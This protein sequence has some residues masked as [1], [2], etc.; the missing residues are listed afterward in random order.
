MPIFSDKSQKSKTT[1]QQVNK[2]TRPQVNEST[3]LYRH[4]P[5]GVYHIQPNGHRLGGYATKD[6]RQR[7]F[8]LRL[9]TEKRNLRISVVSTFVIPLTVILRNDS[10]AEKTFAYIDNISELCAKVICPIVVRI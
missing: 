3:R 9:S 7:I 1:S 4:E 2:T 10:E 5:E 8:V 6:M